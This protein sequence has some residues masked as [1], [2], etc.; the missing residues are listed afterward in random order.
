MADSQNE[1]DQQQE[2]QPSSSGKMKLIIIAIVAV[3]VLAGGGGAAAYFMGLFDG[4]DSAVDG[5]SGSYDALMDNED[6]KN[7]AG[8]NDSADKASQLKETD[9][10]EAS[11][12]DNVEKQGLAQ[13]VFVDLPDV[14]VNLQSENRRARYLKLK[15]SLEVVDEETAETVSNLIPRILDSFQLYL[16]ALTAEEVRG[17]A[18]MQRLKAEML[19]RINNAIEPIRI[20][21]LLFKEMLVQ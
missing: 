21:D 4:N 17:S 6:P 10:K 2:D 7:N 8:G 16:R 5:S 20:S 18:G 14:L 19:A 1:V 15:V 12:D 9:S 11:S 3:V 13:T